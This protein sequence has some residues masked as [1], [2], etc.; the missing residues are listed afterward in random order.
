MG[1]VKLPIFMTLNK[2]NHRP[3]Y[4]SNPQILQLLNK[5]TIMAKNKEITP[6]EALTAIES[7]TTQEQ[8][9]I[10][11]AIET[12]LENKSKKASEELSLINGNKK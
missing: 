6:Q 7:F 11:A 4:T 12:I 2:A 9:S 10:K 8:L 3:K 1:D 5:Q